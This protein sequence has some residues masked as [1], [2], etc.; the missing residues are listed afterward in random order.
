[1]FPDFMSISHRQYHNN[2]QVPLT[3][4]TSPGLYIVSSNAIEDPKAYAM[5]HCLEGAKACHGIARLSDNLYAVLTSRTTYRPPL[6][7]SQLEAG[8]SALWQVHISRWENSRVVL[9][10]KLADFR[11]SGL[12]TKMAAIPSPETAAQNTVPDTCKRPQVFITGSINGA[13][14]LFDPNIGTTSTW[15]SHPGMACAP[16]ENLRRERPKMLKSINPFMH[17]LGNYWYRVL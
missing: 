16:F 12:L 15:L 2:K 6:N 4:Y 9:V 13:F 10:E 11:E 3:L 7:H 17:I 8:T 14:L 1:M 5:L